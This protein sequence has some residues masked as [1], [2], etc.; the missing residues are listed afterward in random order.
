MAQVYFADT[1]AL[2]KR[3][4]DE[5]GSAWVQAALHPRSGATAYIVHITAVELISAITRRE[6]GGTIAPSDAS[7]ARNAFRAHLSAEYKIIR[8]SDALISNAI[9]LAEI[10]GLR[11]YDAVQL[12]AA[13]EVDSLYTAQGFPHITLISSDNELNSAALAEGLA[14]ANPSS[15]P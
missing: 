10:H 7:A 4:V 8:M 11:G 1:S 5:A 15:L 3:Y 2:S 9:N 12:A 6:R 14:V 13:K